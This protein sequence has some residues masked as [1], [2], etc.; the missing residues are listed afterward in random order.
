MI[1]IYFL[2]IIVGILLIILIGYQSQSIKRMYKS[3]VLKNLTTNNN[4]SSSLISENDIKH[5]PAPVQKYLHYVGVIGTEKVHN[6]RIV[7]EGMMRQNP[8]QK[9]NKFRFEQYNFFDQP[10]RFFYIRGS[11][12]GIPAI[13]LD[14]YQHGK[15]NMLIRLGSLLTVVD[16]KDS[17]MDQAALV[18]LFNDMCFFAPGSLIDQ[19]IQWETIDSLTVKATFKDNGLK[20]AGVLYFNDQGA[21]I[22]F[23]TDDRY[24]SPTG[25]TYQKVRWSTPISNY[26]VIHGI[27]L[28]TYGEAV[29]HF[30]EGDFCYGK[31]TKLKEV[32]YNCKSFQ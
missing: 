28:A 29:W 31:F 27:K 18:T 15:G 13:G 1:K 25:K 12:F 17:R 23:V 7:L 14:S 9:W 10:A 22:N 21:L 24:F 4:K 6:V 11:I 8:G 19:R 2:I 26:Q 5:L 30:K 20:I 16:A 3:A 32:E